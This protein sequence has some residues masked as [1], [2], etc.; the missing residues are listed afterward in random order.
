MAWW[1]TLTGKS[2]AE[3][4][5]EAADIQREYGEKALELQRQM[6]EQGRQDLMPW[7][8][9]GQESLGT[10]QGLMGR[11]EFDI[12]PET[13][14]FEQD[15]YYEFIRGEGLRGLE[16]SAAGRG[17]LA[18]GATLAGL[19]ARN[20]ALAGQFYGQGYERARQSRMDRFNRLAGLAGTGQAQSRTLASLGQGYGGQAGAGLTGIGNVLGAGRVGAANVKQQALG[21]LLG[22]GMQLGGQLAGA[23][24]IA[25]DRRLKKNITKIG[26]WKSF[27]KYL[28]Q[29]RGGN[30]WFIGLMADNVKQLRPDAVIN[31]NGFDHVNYGVL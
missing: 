21:N 4:A 15:P 12:S 17:G 30:N 8:T 20:Q 1:N 11:G 14:R 27:D 18:S 22:S 3:A 13:Y 28:F 26:K 5:T 16:R 2:A 10:L 19:M 29:Y 6:Y 31:I 7:L 24:L 9:A 23:A 25:S